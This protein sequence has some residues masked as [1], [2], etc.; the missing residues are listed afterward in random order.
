MAPFE[1][2]MHDWFGTPDWVAKDQEVRQV[3][4]RGA[5]PNPLDAQP[6]PVFS[7]ESRVQFD[8]RPLRGLEDNRSSVQQNGRFSAAALEG[9]GRWGFLSTCVCVSP[10]T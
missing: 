5:Q 7:V 9:G 3:G 10:A 4:E 1:K 6:N 2:E 8:S